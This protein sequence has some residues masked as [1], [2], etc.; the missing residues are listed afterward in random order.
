MAEIDRTRLAGRGDDFAMRGLL[1][2]VGR[3][4]SERAALLAE[5][6]EDSRHLAMRSRP[7]ASRCIVATDIGEQKQHQ[8]CAISRIDVDSPSQE[9]RMF[10]SVARIDMPTGVPGILRGRE[11]YRERTE[12]FARRPSPG[13]HKLIECAPEDRRT[14]RG[15][16][17]RLCI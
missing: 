11:P 10:D 4:L 9:V 3:Q 12:A 17:G 15:G 13:A 6:R 2:A 7:D 5:G 1:E 14:G 16:K 8:Q